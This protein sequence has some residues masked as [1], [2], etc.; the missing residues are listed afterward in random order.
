MTEQ[1]SNCFF[2]KSVTAHKLDGTGRTIDGPALACRFWPPTPQRATETTEQLGWTTVLPTDWC[3]QYAPDSGP[4]PGYGRPGIVNVASVVP[5][6]TVPAPVVNV[7]GPPS[8]TININAPKG[9][10]GL[11]GNDGAPGQAGKGFDSAVDTYRD[12]PTT[13]NANPLVMRSI[14]MAVNST[15]LIES[16][17]QFW[18]NS[19]LSGGKMRI[20]AAFGRNNTGDPVALG[21]ASIEETHNL[22]VPPVSLVINSAAKTIDIT[23]TGVQGTPIHWSGRTTV[24]NG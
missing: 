23:L 12:R 11:P 20:R 1:C 10:P 3:G 19:H 6:V 22:V 21:A 13:P 17:I 16:F 15:A 2:V 7:A 9:D 18:D 4:N 14:P 24:D 5:S 8:P